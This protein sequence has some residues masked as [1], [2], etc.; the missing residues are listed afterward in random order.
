MKFR[1]L[2]FK[3]YTFI[4]IFRYVIRKKFFNAEF[5][6]KLFLSVNR[7]AIVPL[8][9]YNK[10]NIGDNTKIDSPLILHYYNKDLS[11]LYIGNNCSISKNCFLDLSEKIT[12]E[13]NCT[14]AMN[15][16]IVTH[17]DLGKSYPEKHLKNDKSQ[18]TISEGSYVGA[19][20]LILKGVTIGEQSFIGA[21]SLVSQSTPEG[22]FIVGVPGRNK[23][24]QND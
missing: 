2:L 19:N 13:D 6:N 22:S 18:V 12:I 24:Y 3:I 8:L 10:A 17:I 14:L 11:K 20:V 5:A 16:T 7:D 15:V 1:L 9:R 4:Y 21:K 23:K